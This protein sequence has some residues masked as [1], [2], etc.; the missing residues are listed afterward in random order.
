MKDLD[1][2]PLIHT[3]V[4]FDTNVVPGRGLIAGLGW[5]LGW[6]REKK[7]EL[8]ESAFIER[9]EQ[10]K[11]ALQNRDARAVD[12]LNVPL[13]LLAKIAKEIGMTVFTNNVWRNGGGPPFLFTK[14]DYDDTIYWQDQHYGAS[15]SPSRPGESGYTQRKLDEIWERTR[16]S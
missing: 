15:K 9:M 1:L 2:S 8:I 13:S 6:S 12:E 4:D 3:K 16:G 10:L 5:G 7:A 14:R 11:Q